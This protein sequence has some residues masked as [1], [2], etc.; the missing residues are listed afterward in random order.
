MNVEIEVG[1]FRG[2]LPMRGGAE[3]FV[4]GRQVNDMSGSVW[5]RR[6]DEAFA[7]KMDC[8]LQVMIH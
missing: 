1:D 7:N 2:S 5:I 4:S 8:N 6:T 3:F